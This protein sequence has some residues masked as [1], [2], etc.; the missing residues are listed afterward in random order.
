MTK[1]RFAAR[2]QKIWR[3]WPLGTSIARPLGLERLQVLTPLRHQACRKPLRRQLLWRHIQ[4]QT[5]RQRLAPRSTMPLYFAALAAV[6]SITASHDATEKKQG[7]WRCN[8]CCVK[9]TSLRRGFGQ[10]PP[11]NWSDIPVAT[12]LE[13]FQ[14]SDGLSTKDLTKK[15]D[16]SFHV[17]DVLNQKFY[18]HG[19]DFLP[20]SVWATRG[21]NTQSIADHTLE[22]DKRL[23]PVL[24]L[25]YRV[26]ILAL[27][28]RGEE[29]VRTR[30]VLSRTNKRAK[31]EEEEKEQEQEEQPGQEQEGNQPAGETLR[32]QKKNT[33][34][35]NKKSDISSADGEEK[36]ADDSSGED[37]S[38]SSSSSSKTSSSSSGRKKK[39]HSHKKSKKKKSKKSKGSKKEKSAKKNKKQAAAQKKKEQED[40]Q[41]AKAQEK[42][43]TKEDSEVKKAKASKQKLATSIVTKM[44]PVMSALSVTLQKPQLLKFP[45]SIRATGEDAYG[46]LRAL[47]QRCNLVISA[48]DQSVDL[49]D[50]KVLITKL[51]NA[52]KIDALLTGMCASQS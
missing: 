5:S 17:K 51:V 7:V 28:E 35:K 42:A 47:Q 15:A 21:F 16:E 13:F 6:K 23:H 36:S 50:G 29:N 12:Q 10:W 37:D 46:E 18:T 2:T 1:T 26:K 20:L 3:F 31:T 14:C 41:L 9:I 27:G 44:T 43:Q 33:K 40:K 38:R 48:E 8:K 11:P 19:G 49:I 45:S 39:K 24:G 22:G 34:G 32:T 52:R 30:H 4:S 25:T